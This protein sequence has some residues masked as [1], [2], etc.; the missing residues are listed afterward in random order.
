MLPDCAYLLCCCCVLLHDFVLPLV[1]GPFFFGWTVCFEFREHQIKFVRVEFLSVCI[2]FSFMHRTHYKE[3]LMTWFISN[4]LLLF[5]SMLLYQYFKH[6]K[7]IDLIWSENGRF[8]L[9]LWASEH[10]H[11]L[12]HV[13]QVFVKMNRYIPSYVYG[14][15]WANSCAVCMDRTYIFLQQ[16]PNIHG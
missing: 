6:L 7:Y 3:V 13:V 12:L 10:Y 15:F 4:N 1:C 5:C 14:E 2:F 16:H 8:C 11:H 9:V